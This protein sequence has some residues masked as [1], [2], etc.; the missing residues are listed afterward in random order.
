MPNFI[1]DYAQSLAEGLDHVRSWVS[2]DISDAI[3]NI[4]NHKGSRFGSLAA[5]S[6]NA[7]GKALLSF[8]EKGDIPSFKQW[9]FVAG[10]IDKVIISERLIG[11]YLVGDLCWALLSDCEEL[12]QWYS[13]SVDRFGSVTTMEGRDSPE[14]WP[15]YRYQAYLALRGDFEKLGARAKIFLA[16]ANKISKWKWVVCEYE[17]HNALAEGNLQEMEKALQEMI[18]PSRLKRIYKNQNGLTG[19]LIEQ[20]ATV[21]A[22]I[23]WRH[24]YKVNIGSP[25]IPQALLPVDPVVDYYDPWT[26]F[27]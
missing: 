19:N 26:I 16:L 9:A 23:A 24:G 25:W 20:H 1:S 5:L 7:A 27:A 12:I 15:F 6:R 13:Q 4:H 10:S 11:D 17:F 3:D 2:V 14:S 21:Y 8:Y 22:K 18:S